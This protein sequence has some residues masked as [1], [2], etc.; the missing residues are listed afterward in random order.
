MF[1]L[2]R[3]LMKKIWNLEGV[4]VQLEDTLEEQQDTIVEQQRR[5]EELE[6]SH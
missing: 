6:G 4:I 1:N 3:Y 5:I 2:T